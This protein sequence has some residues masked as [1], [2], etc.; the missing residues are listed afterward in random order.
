VRTHVGFDDPRLFWRLS[1][2]EIKALTRKKEYKPG[3]SFSDF[4]ITL[5][6]DLISGLASRGY[7]WRERTYPND[8]HGFRSGLMDLER[9]LDARIP[10]MIDT[11]LHNGHTFV[12]A[13]YSVSDGALWIVDPLAPPPGIRAVAFGELEE[14]WNSSATVFNGRAAVFPRRRRGGAQNDR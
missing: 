6:P 10:V 9:S 4:S 12:V 13:G 7:A 14:I 1:P 5:F 3:D 11:V 8:D 2:R